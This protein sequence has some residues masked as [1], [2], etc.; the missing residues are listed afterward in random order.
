MTKITFNN[1]KHLKWQGAILILLFF[2]GLK[3]FSQGENLITN[4]DI[5]SSGGWTVYNHYNRVDP[6]NGT[7]SPR[8]YAIASNAQQFNSGFVSATPHSGTSMLV[9]DSTTDGGQQHFWGID[10]C[11]L[12][13]GVEHTFSFWMRSVSAGNL[14]D[15]EMIVTSGASSVQR[16]KGT[17]QAPDVNSGWQ[18]YEYK[19]TPTANCVSIRLRHTNAGNYADGLGRDFALDDFSLIAPPAPLSIEYFSNPASCPGNNDAYIEAT[20]FGGTGPF[21]YDLLNSLGATVATNATGNFINLAPDTYTVTVTDGLGATDTTPNI[22]LQAP[23]EIT[24]SPNVTICNGASTNLSVS[25]STSTYTWTAQPADGSITDP[26]LPNQTVSPTQT[27]TYTVTSTVVTNSSDALNLLTNGGFGAGNFGFESDYNYTPDNTAAK[28]QK[29]YGIVANPR[30]WEPDFS[31]CTDRSTDNDLMMVVDGSA[32]AANNDRVWSQTVNG[33][34]QNT[35]YIFSYWVQSV[36]ALS[37]ANLETQINGSVVGTALAPST[38]C[39]WIRRFYRWNSG[40]SNSAIITIIDRNTVVAGNDFALDEMSFA[41]AIICELEKSV[42]VTVNPVVVPTFDFGTSLTINSGDVVPN[43]P[44]SSNNATP[45]TGTWNPAVIDNTQSGVYEFTPNDPSQCGSGVQLSI[46]VNN[47]VK[48]DPQFNLPAQICEGTDVSLPLVSVNAISGTWNPSVINTT[49][50]GSYVF[51]PDDLILANTYQYDL[52]VNLRQNLTVPA[53]TTTYC[54]GASSDALPIPNEAVT[55]TWSAAS[56]STA[57]AGSIDYVFT[58]DA[59]QCFNPF[60]LPVTVNPTVEPT[61]SFVTTYDVGEV[62]VVL[63]ATSDNGITGTWNPANI[64]TSVSGNV[65]YNFTPNDASQCGEV[66]SR[67]I[68]VNNILFIDPIFTLPATIC[69]GEAVSLPLISDNGIN[70]TWNPAVVDNTQS[71]SYSFTPDGGQNANPYAYNLTVNQPVVPT[72]NNL[73]SNTACENGAVGVLP[74]ASV[75]GITGTW[76]GVLDSSILG[77]TTYTF[78][79]DAG[80]CASSFPFDFTVTAP[81]VPTFNNLPSNSTCENGAVGVLPT[82]SVEGITGTWSGALDSSVLGLST[83]TFT[84]DAGQCASSVPFEFTVT[85]PT[86]PTFNNLP[87]NTACENGAVGVLPTA[88]VEGITGTWSGVLDSSILGLS[89]YTFTPDAGQCASSFPFDFT[90]TAPIT[91]TFNGMPSATVCQTDAVNIFPTT[92][93]EGVTGTWSPVLDLNVI[94]LTNY[95]F[96]PDAGQCAQGTGFDLTVNAVV[97]PTFNGLPNPMVCQNENVSAL[98]TTSDNGIAGTWSP[99]LSTAT[100]G[101]TTYTFTP[102]VGQCA[103]HYL[104]H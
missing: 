20:R 40:A 63:P 50:S 13:T 91:P 38:A 73:P 93:I 31:T 60:I 99:A 45:I 98:P 104:S 54:V 24:T 70:G 30:L 37:P 46:T 67:I 57:V 96:T 71:G 32:T 47:I 21:S 83:Y 86:V 72:F 2:F 1:R 84:P 75:E 56:I 35:D 77:L 64:D 43:L 52:T 87:S 41:E 74:T 8:Q 82:A 42:T 17:A 97:T 5:E 16:T 9:F 85:V 36:A 61:F 18:E 94:G 12:N 62:P 33:L 53:I 34:K 23:V 101:A 49:Q 51:T 26:S 3:G 15:V 27:T 7:S 69:R 11:A 76:S 29:A 66:T 68:T 81:I 89:T 100:V 58:P 19:F 44:T 14:A 103:N 80:Q 28:A 55:G 102:D 59:G 48:I 25:G 79:P 22:Q 4:G 65:T 6:P 39:G 10:V 95:I 78:T 92:S 88:S 90:V